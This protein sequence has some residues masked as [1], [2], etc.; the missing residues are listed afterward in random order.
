MD[1]YLPDLSFLSKYPAN[2]KAEISSLVHSHFLIAAGSWRSAWQNLAAF[3]LKLEEAHIANSISDKFD[4]TI[5]HLN[6]AGIGEMREMMRA[7]VLLDDPRYSEILKGKFSPKQICGT[8]DAYK[9]NQMQLEVDAEIKYQITTDVENLSFASLATTDVLP[10]TPNLA[11][12]SGEDSVK[13]I[14]DLLGLAYIDQF[15]NAYPCDFGELKRPDFRVGTVKSKSDPRLGKGFY[16]ENSWRLTA[17]NKDLGLFYL[18]YQIVQY[19]DLPTIVIYDSP[20]TS[21]KV[22]DWAQKFQSRHEH[23]NRLFAVCTF[24]QFREWSLRKL[25]RQA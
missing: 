12:A 4:L 13:S 25:G 16:I 9:A 7:K 8:V 21:D 19:S 10:V 2:A 5:K 6:P 11:G 18:L 15:P 24:Q 20:S 14:L 3:A 17:K 23:S 1:D 22:W